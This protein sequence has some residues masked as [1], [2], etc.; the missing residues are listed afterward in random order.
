MT[1]PGTR[2]Q[3][4]YALISILS[5][6]F[7]E[8][9]DSTNAF[10][11]HNPD[12]RDR[13]MY[14]E[15]LN[16]TLRWLKYLD[17]VLDRYY[18]KKIQKS[19]ELFR[20][21]LESGLYQM[22]FMDR[23]PLYAA[24]NETV[25]LVKKSMGKYWAGVANGVLRSIAKDTRTGFI[26]P[27]KDDPAEYCA[28]RWS[29]PQWFVNKISR[30]FGIDTA[31][32]LCR[33]N[34]ERPVYSIR[35]HTG[36]ASPGQVLQIVRSYEPDAQKSLFLDEFIRVPGLGKILGSDLFKNGV[37]SVQ[38]ES[39]GFVA[40]LTDP[41]PDEIIADVAAAPGGKVCHM[42]ELAP[43]SKL[44][45]MDISRA[46]SAKIA[47]NCKRLGLGSVSLAVANILAL[48]LAQ[49]DKIVLDAPCSGMGVLAKRA[50]LRWKRTPGHIEKIYALQA[51]LLEACAAHLQ[52]GGV[53]VYS[54]CTIL[55]EENR[56]QV[57]NFLENHPEFCVENAENFVHSDVVDNN[58]FICTFPHI[59]AVDGSFAVRL[60]KRII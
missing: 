13:A 33:K 60:K 22:L 14:T 52:P 20:R 12:I 5:A 21:A 16:G 27:P 8:E 59:H 25:S 2:K 24:I 53:L 45:A 10:A 42:A 26:E 4:V 29:H 34:N 7:R 6:D 17:W 51:E 37:I 11:G 38:D 40:H 43:R 50:D 56:D 49:V 39:A 1:M 47:E 23:I 41:K 18:H 32:A 54:T 57:F 15:L 19:P 9:H 35:V 36:K 3:V 30:S 46:R 44:I 58:G 28:V 31:E 55:D 48:P